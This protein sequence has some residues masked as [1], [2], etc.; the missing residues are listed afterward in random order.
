LFAL[1]DRYPGRVISICGN[2]E[3][4][5]I[6][7]Y[8]TGKFHGD[9]AGHLEGRLSAEKVHELRRRF[10]TWPMLV[11]LPSCGVV[12]SHGA[13]EPASVE[14]LEQLRY[15]GPCSRRDLLL[16]AMSRYGF[17]PGEDVALL[18]ALSD[19]RTYNVLLHGH[20]REE[21]GFSRNGAAAL[22][23]CTSFGARQ[24]RKTYAWLDL[25][26]R[27]ASLDDLEGSGALRRL[28]PELPDP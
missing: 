16:C 10:A 26:H 27:Y 24:P 21:E 11:R 12:V 9:E 3:H 19:D 23:L 14:E 6:G 15:Q 22:L 25:A 17:K 5:H 2:H 20:D 28:Y 13:P 7:G 1:M 4:A 8:R 18:A